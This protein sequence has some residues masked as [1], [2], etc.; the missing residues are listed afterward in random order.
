MKK[1]A[2]QKPQNK[3]TGTTRVHTSKLSVASPKI[4]SCES[5]TLRANKFASFKPA[6]L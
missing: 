1:S 6:I 4:V 2:E 3:V 5:V